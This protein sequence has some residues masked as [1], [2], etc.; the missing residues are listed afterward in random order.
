MGER[1]SVGCSAL[2]LAMLAFGSTPAAACYLGDCDSLGYYE[3]PTTYGYVAP[4]YGY[5]A[6]VYGYAAPT[7]GY[8]GSA[9]RAY[10]Y[11]SPAYGYAAPVYGYAYPRYYGARRSFGARRYYGAPRYYARLATTMARGGVITIAQG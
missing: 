8:G 11:A 5:A 1:M 9:Y 4:V 10:G 2:I 7:Y 3:T 6:P